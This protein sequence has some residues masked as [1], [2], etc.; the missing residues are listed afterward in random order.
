MIIRYLREKKIVPAFFSTLLFG[1]MLGLYLWNIFFGY[2]SS[3]YEVTFDANWIA[4]PDVKV[5]QSY[6][7][8]KIYLNNKEEIRNAWLKVSGPDMFIMYINGVITGSAEATSDIAT[9]FYN[10]TTSLRD[11]V[12][13]I[14][15]DNNVGISDSSRLLVEGY[16]EDITGVKRRFASDGTWKVSPYEPNQI[17]SDH[18]WDDISFRDSEWKNAT[19]LKD[20]SIPKKGRVSFDPLVFTSPL[21]GE[22]VWT[23]SNTDKRV[24]FRYSLDIQD[25]TKIRD[26]WLRMIVEERNSYNLIVN[27]TPIDHI[28]NIGTLGPISVTETLNIYN[29][30]QY[31][32]TGRNIISL[33]AYSE[34]SNPRIYIDGIISDKKVDKIGDKI[35]YFSRG[36]E[37]TNALFTDLKT[38][39]YDASRWRE[40]SNVGRVMNSDIPKTRILTDTNPTEGYLFCYYLKKYSF[41]G[42]VALLTFI[43]WFLI[44]FIFSRRKDMAI[45]NSLSVIGLVNFFLSFILVFIYILSFDVRLYPAYPYQLKFVILTFFVFIFIFIILLFWKHEE[46]DPSAPLTASSSLKDYIFIF[47]LLAAG[48]VLRLYTVDFKPLGGDEITMYYYSQGVLDDFY[49]YL[50]VAPNLPKKITTTSEIVPYFM[51]IGIKLFGPNEFGIRFSGI[52]WG[53]LTILLLY[54]T[55]KDIFNRRVG[56]LASV[57]YAFMPV[58][59][60]YSQFA[61]YPSQ[62]QFFSLFS[63]YLFY[64][65]IS[66]K[67]I[68]RKY[69]YLTSMAFLMSY[70]SWEGAGFLLPSFFGALLLYKRTDF[71]WI[72]SKHL[73][74]AVSITAFVVFSHLSSKLI[75]TQK[76][77]MIFGTGVSSIS[78]TP[79]WIEPVFDPTYYIKNFYLL[80]NMMPVSFFFMAGFLFFLRNRALSFFYGIIIVV[81]FFMT[82]FFEI[83][84]MRYLYFIL[85]LV[86]LS[87]SSVF[88]RFL[89]Y[90]L[91]HRSKV[92]LY[93]GRITKTLAFVIILLLSNDFIMKPYN[94]PGGSSMTSTK[95]YLFDVNNRAAITYLHEH[96]RPGDV[97]IS[98]WAHVFKFFLGRCEY[99]TENNLVIPVAVLRD[100]P[101]AGHRITGSP[102]ISNISN[103]EDI[104]RKHE[105]AWFVFSTF[106][107]NYLYPEYVDFIKR[108]AHSVFEDTNIVVYLWDR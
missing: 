39:T 103:L 64:K 6:F 4:Y 22:F 15:I 67:E 5:H 94:I 84:S 73:W 54:I 7:R 76:G 99:Y 53:A 80:D 85:P 34:K 86:L 82:F 23:D 24:F 35:F 13:V 69:I 102:L 56:L 108:S 71:S 27:G 18:K 60:N 50:N 45:N 44:A 49:P 70:F 25:R 9:N 96:I 26:V 106:E 97:I 75:Y 12:N 51:A 77:R 20:Q 55:G 61:R 81:T 107:I 104:L 52:F 93:I 74:Y 89:D 43:L 32:H 10:I 57:I 90:F 98:N 30:T 100:K 11:G 41:I 31:L 87:G 21:D 62:V 8:K 33:F 83:K 91:S 59:I 72:K 19:V 101:A 29:I 48:F 16:Y 66:D 40:P 3:Q 79:Q 36:G 14:A 17:D 105:R 1:L 88:F 63:V 58:T 37:C 78:L 65:S 95:S 2:L 47:I 92:G 38:A 46:P 68:S 28:N 42:M